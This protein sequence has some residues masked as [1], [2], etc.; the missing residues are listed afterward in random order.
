MESELRLHYERAR[1]TIDGSEQDVV[2]EVPQTRD[3]SIRCR[4]VFLER[5]PELAAGRAQRIERQYL[6]WTQE[7]ELG[8]VHARDPLQQSMIGRDLILQ[9]AE[10]GWGRE[11]RP[12]A[13]RGQGAGE[14]QA[15]LA[16]SPLREELAR[17]EAEL[18]FAAYLP[19]QDVEP[20]SRWTVRPS[21]LG[22]L[23]SPGLSIEASLG[24]AV[25]GL[26]GDDAGSLSEGIR[27]WW[28]RLDESGPQLVCTY[29]ERVDTG[30]DSLARVAFL[31]ER[32]DD[33]IASPAARRTALADI[34]LGSVEEGRFS[35]R[36]RTR[37]TGSML[38]D[39]TAGRLRAFDLELGLRITRN[40][41][42][43]LVTDGGRM[44]LAAEQTFRVELE[45]EAEAR[46]EE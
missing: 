41:D 28:R 14:G 32:E 31:L 17:L 18:D 19:P 36:V 43:V 23:V 45:A 5:I 42:L 29:V 6:E 21:V 35:H 3:S 1:T 40:L 9:R 20:G 27:S 4:L 26:P 22:T 44:A 37:V 46:A 8:P 12:R 2:A 13:T 7:D 25:R 34:R 39:L 33:F 15:P 10:D 16:T 24:G 11:L 38:W 30:S